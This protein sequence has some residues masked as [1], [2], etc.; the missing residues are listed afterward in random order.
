MEF[1]AD[2][3]WTQPHIKREKEWEMTGLPL[4][5][6]SLVLGTYK[7]NN[8][9]SHQRDTNFGGASLARRKRLLGT[10]CAAGSAMN[11]PLCYCSN[12]HWPAEP[13]RSELTGSDSVRRL[14]RS[15]PGGLYSRQYSSHLLVFKTGYCC[16]APFGCFAIML[17]LESMILLPQCVDIMWHRQE[18]LQLI[19]KFVGCFLSPANER[20]FT[21][22]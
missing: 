9:T 6:C 2:G 8:Y 19:F 12:R 4:I 13:S 10:F 15:T 11:P 21:N 18:N 3:D 1:S 14:L 17:G 7:I 16:T 22:S 5:F 20:T